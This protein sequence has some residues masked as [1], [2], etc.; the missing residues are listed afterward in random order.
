MP[1]PSLTHALTPA[2][3][4]AQSHEVPWPRDP[5]ADPEH[6]PKFIARVTQAFDECR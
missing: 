3:D 2:I 6:A 1:M 4:F 5:L